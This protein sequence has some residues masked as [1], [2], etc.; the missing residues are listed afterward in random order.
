ML[1]LIQRKKI[2]SLIWGYSGCC[3]VDSSQYKYFLIW[4]E[5]SHENLNSVHTTLVRIA[6]WVDIKQWTYILIQSQLV[7]IDFSGGSKSVTVRAGKK[8]HYYYVNLAI[9]MLF[10]VTFTGGPWLLGSWLPWSSQYRDS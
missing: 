6:T 5:S 7:F 10:A 3:N 1:I 4:F 2:F 9:Q 8:F